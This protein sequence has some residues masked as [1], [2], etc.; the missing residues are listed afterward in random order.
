MQGEPCWVGI[1]VSKAFLDVALSPKGRP[2]QLANDSRGIDQ[3]RRELMRLEPMLVVLEATGGFEARAAEALRTAGLKVAVVN[4]R[5]VR[6][7]ARAMGRLAKTDR[8][9]AETLALFAERVRPEPNQ[10]TSESEQAL[11]ELLS[12]RRQLVEMLT[13]EKNRLGMA[14]PGLRRG[15]EQ[16]I[17]FL[18]K[19]LRQ[20]EEH[21]DQV[22]EQDEKLSARDQL[23][24][25]VPGVGPVLSRTLLGELPELGRLSRKQ[26]AALVGVA[27]LAQDSG[28]MRG[29]RMVWGGRSSVRT[30][31]FMA[32]IV[33]A[34]WNPVIR[35]FYERLRSAGKPAKVALVACM[36]KLLVILNAM[37]KAETAWNPKLLG[38]SS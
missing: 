29:K 28:T 31:L 15:I 20:V 26:I 32:A 36:R 19:Q 33:A 38:A 23:L 8:I 27:P 16:H 12:R 35:A 22:V 10:P 9:D 17:R 13:Q 11:D 2:W 21:L 24:Q 37:V 5:Q 4:P 34:R 6:D 14:R 7:F 30:V 1:D 3:L 18:E 25:T